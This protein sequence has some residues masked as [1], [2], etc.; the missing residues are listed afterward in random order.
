[1]TTVMIKHPSKGGLPEMGQR[2]DMEIKNSKYG[3][4]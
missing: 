2:K 3:P 1:M 4:V